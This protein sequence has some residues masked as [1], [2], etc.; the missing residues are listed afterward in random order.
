MKSYYDWILWNI[1]K[2]FSFYNDF[3][4]KL[5]YDDVCDCNDLF[6]ISYGGVGW[7]REKAKGEII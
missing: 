7:L 3:Y 6:D 1:I 2:F 5:L 4:G